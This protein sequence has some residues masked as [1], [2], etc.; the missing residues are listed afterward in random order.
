MKSQ[1]LNRARV[2]M[3][4]PVARDVLGHRSR[5]GLGRSPPLRRRLRASNCGP[6]MTK[7]QPEAN[8]TIVSTFTLA[9]IAPKF[10]FG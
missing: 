2:S 9:I 8:R 3:R 1:I 6:Q 5:T 4:K 7:A 10:T